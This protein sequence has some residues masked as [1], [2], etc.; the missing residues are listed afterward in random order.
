MKAGMTHA[1]VGEGFW[2]EDMG[3]CRK[4]RAAGVTVGRGGGSLLAGR[5][6]NT[7]STSVLHLSFP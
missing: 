2:A 5:V 4:G 6:C 3:V 7:V 1:G